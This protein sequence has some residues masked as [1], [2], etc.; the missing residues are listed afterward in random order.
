[1]ASWRLARSLE[2]LRDEIRALHPGTTVWTIGDEAHVVSDH[3]PNAAGVVCAI[4]VLGDGGLDLARFAE[5]V[6]TSGHPAAKYVI[7]ARRVASAAYGWT[8]RTYTGSNPHTT[9]VHVSVG[10]GPDGRSTGPYDDTSPWGLASTGGIEMFCKRGD[11]GPTVEALQR[12]LAVAGHPPEGGA[13]GDYGPATSRAL[14]A[15]RQE[16]GTQATSGD[17]YTPA[18]YAQLFQLLAR[19]QGSGKQGERGPA[20]PQGPA[21]PAGPRGERGEPGPAGPPGA[22]PTRI[23]IT[24]EVVAVDRA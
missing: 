12:L 2:V 1:M 7:H 19:K 21:G 14:F 24:G 9:H 15:A 11:K 10:V 4:D 17:E 18:A 13:D 3:R 23:A 8:W 22:T 6:R 16:V 5:V 20:G